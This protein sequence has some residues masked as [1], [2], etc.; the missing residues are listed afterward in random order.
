MPA[1]L[2]RGRRPMRS[3]ARTRSCAPNWPAAAWGMSWRWPRATRSPPGPAPARR[4]P[5][6]AWQRLSAGPGAK[7]PRWYDWAFI[8]VTDPAVTGGGLHWL[9]IRR[10]ISDGEYAFY[11]AHAPRPVPLAQL[12]KVAGSRW[13]IEEGFAASKEL[14]AL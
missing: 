8:E 3:T 5:V 1:R 11:R 10:R 14:A 6:R 12:V 2:R 13:K 4:L 7:G 9:L